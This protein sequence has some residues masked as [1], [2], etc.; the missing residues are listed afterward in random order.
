MKTNL[1]S[2]ILSKRNSSLFKYIVVGVGSLAVD[3]VAL[4]FLYRIIN[5]DLALATFV[6][7]LMGLTVNFVLNKFWAFQAKNDKMNNIFQTATYLLLVAFNSL[8]TVI[9]VVRLE[10]IDIP[11]EI[12][13]PLSVVMIT[14]WNYVLYKKVIFK[15]AAD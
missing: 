3:Y 6:S 1:L 13:K 9:A 12:S 10:A 2:V 5:V 8:F 4:L 15:K 11:P 7:F 14:L